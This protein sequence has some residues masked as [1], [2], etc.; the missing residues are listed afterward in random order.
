MFISKDCKYFPC[1]IGMND[2][3]LCFCPIY[4]CKMKSLGK[5]VGKGKARV[6]DCSDC[7]IFHKYYAL[8]KRS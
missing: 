5:Y 2:C 4:P 3:R 6:W 1:H 7:D 8:K